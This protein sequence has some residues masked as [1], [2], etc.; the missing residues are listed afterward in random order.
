M[1]AFAL[2]RPDH[3]D[4]AA[5]IADCERWAA[6]KEADVLRLAEQDREAEADVQQARILI[7]YLRTRLGT[8]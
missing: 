8:P 3:P 7:A 5:V 4:L 1:S 6:E 2:P